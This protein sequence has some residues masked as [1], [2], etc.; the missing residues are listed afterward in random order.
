MAFTLNVPIVS[1]YSNSTQN[2]GSVCKNGLKCNQFGSRNNRMTKIFQPFFWLL[3]INYK[4][5]TGMKA[6][7]KCFSVVGVPQLDFDQCNPDEMIQIVDA[8]QGIG[9]KPGT[10]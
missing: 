9:Q 7:N 2:C 8:V 4:S 6:A 10:S 5:A 3:L 1:L